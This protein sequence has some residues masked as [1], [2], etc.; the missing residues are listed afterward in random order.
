MKNAAVSW[1]LLIVSSLAVAD[2]LPSPGFFERRFLER[3]RSN[4]EAID[5]T[6][7]FCQ[8][9]TIGAACVVTGTP[10]EGGGEGICRRQVVNNFIERSLDLVCEIKNPPRV[11]RQI[12]HS[13]VQEN[14]GHCATAADSVASGRRSDAAGSSGCATAVSEAD[15]FCRGKVAG[16]NC[17]ATLSDWSGKV[18]VDYPGV[19]R[20]LN[21][22]VRIGNRL[23]GH[24]HTREW[25]QCEPERRVTRVMR[26]V[27]GPSA[28]G[29]A[30]GG[31]PG[32][33]D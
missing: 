22:D 26:G 15:R 8:G 5:R 28:P 17:L 29:P 16:D 33:R 23:R 19:C 10:F 2:V 3:A 25:L 7:Q 11:D 9:R 4:P 14:K 18:S 21:E 27:S 20:V 12:S 32:A 31:V 6:D 24:V 13:P 30:P 1:A